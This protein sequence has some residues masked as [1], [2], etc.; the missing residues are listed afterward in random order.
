MKV[1]YYKHNQLVVSVS[2]AVLVMVSL[3]EQ[4]NT[5]SGIW[6]VDIDLVNAFFSI[7][8]MKED[9]LKFKWDRWQCY[10]QSCP[11]LC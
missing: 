10:L 11:G 8:I 3:L 6:Y 9:Q 2:A 1:N 4:V 5:V 7:P